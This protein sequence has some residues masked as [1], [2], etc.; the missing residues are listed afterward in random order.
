MFTGT[1]VNISNNVAT[2]I[3]KTCVNQVYKRADRILDGQDKR[4][5]IGQVTMI[6]CGYR[7]NDNIDAMKVQGFLRSVR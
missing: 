1:K 3:R 4:M 2:V 6:E 5:D 7:R